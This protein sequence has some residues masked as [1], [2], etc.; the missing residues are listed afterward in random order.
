MEA[1]KQATVLLDLAKQHM[2]RFHELEDIEWRINFAVWGF[3]GALGY[4]WVSGHVP[5]PPWLMT[6][7][8]LLLPDCAF[9]L[10]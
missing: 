3:W 6:W 7:R 2:Q 10:A 4:L 5:V 9:C 8:A 1:D